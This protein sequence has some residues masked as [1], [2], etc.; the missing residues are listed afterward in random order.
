MV[1]V[2]KINYTSINIHHRYNTGT[3]LGTRQ[4]TNTPIHIYSPR[5]YTN[6]TN[7]IQSPVEAG[8]LERGEDTH[9]KITEDSKKSR[10][11]GNTCMGHTHNHH[12]R[13]CVLFAERKL[14]GGEREN[15]KPRLTARGEK[16]L[17]ERERDTS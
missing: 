7:K 10:N 9:L 14:E 17:G 11:S 2:Q 5:N 4:H 15:K 12:E 8:N 6:Y 3:I 16:A 13:E 1:Y